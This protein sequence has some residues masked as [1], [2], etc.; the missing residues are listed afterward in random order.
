MADLT[1]TI[2]VTGKGNNMII[3]YPDDLIPIHSVSGAAYCRRKAVLDRFV[4]PYR[5][6]SLESRQN[7]SSSNFEILTYTIARI[8]IL[9]CLQSSCWDVEWISER[10]WDVL[11]MNTAALVRHGSVLKGI[12]E[13]LVFPLVASVLSFKCA[14]LPE[15]VGYTIFHFLIRVDKA[16][17]RP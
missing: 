17:A 5:R 11:R 12:H 14:I 9:A 2:H 15:L 16:S 4:T 3:L 6:P 1:W 8:V 7:I 10:I 13:R